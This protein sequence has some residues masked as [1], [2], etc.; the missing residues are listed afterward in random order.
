MGSRSVEP[1]LC[2]QN[3][4]AAHRHHPASQQGGDGRLKNLAGGARAEMEERWLGQGIFKIINIKIVSGSISA[5]SEAT[6]TI[7]EKPLKCCS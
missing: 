7:G 1:G 4:G 6:L 2:H 5:F 3:G